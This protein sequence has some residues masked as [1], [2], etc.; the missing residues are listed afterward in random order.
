[1]ELANATNL[2]WS[3][4]K[5]AVGAFF[6]A[7]R[8]CEFSDVGGPCRTRTL[9]L[10]DIEFRREGRKI[11]SDED[12]GEIAA[13]DTVSMTFR[14]QKN[15]EKGTTVTQHRNSTIGEARIC[16]VIS[17]ARLVARVSRYEPNEPKW[18]IRDH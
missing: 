10:G 9:T 15:G 17:L 13:A 3:A 14:T 12:E 8:A 4:G 11:E 5:L 7:M 2:H 18:K 6:F 16:P 1:M